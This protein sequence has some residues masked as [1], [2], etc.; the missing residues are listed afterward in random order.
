MTAVDDQRQVAAASLRRIAGL[1]FIRGIAIILVLCRHLHLAVP[2]IDSG[3][4]HHALYFLQRGGWC[5]VDLFFVLSGFLV[6]GILFR[7]H[8][9]DGRLHVGEFLI[10][11]GFKI[12]PAF[13]IMLEATVIYNL[14]AGG[15]IP[16]RSLC[17][18]LLFIQNYFK[19]IYGHTWSL[20]V[21]EHCYLGIVL[22]LLACL[23]FAPRADNPFRLLPLLTGAG[24]I[25]A[26]WLRQRL[27]PGLEQYGPSSI[28]FPTQLRFD[29]FLS[30]A[31]LAY[32]SCY[33]R[34]I[35]D[36]LCNFGRRLWIIFGVVLLLPV[37]LF[38][39]RHDP[40][41]IRWCLTINIGVVIC[42]ILAAHTRS[43]RMGKPA[44]NFGGIPNFGRTLARGIEFVGENSYSIYLWHELLE[45]VVV[46]PMF[47]QR[48][49]F[50]VEHVGL[51][52]P[53]YLAVT[54][55]GGIFLA[56]LIEHPTLVWRDRWFP[57]SD[58]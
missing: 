5:G 52:A 54:I 10:R 9:R 30:G 48:I 31:A 56:Y 29:G 4:L 3:W 41:V 37:F 44:A 15:T 23:R 51:W 11:R 53:V 32:L 43:T 6:S 49:T 22:L 46:R 47:R 34:P 7:H 42:W 14:L 50:P 36:R 20:A 21:E 57:R 13:W 25:T 58:D 19:G 55:A 38:D 26:W 40:F 24:L 45:H 16:V 28:L 12:Y 33:R 35:F 2:D 39:V 27:L 18:E 8:Q 17:I 1:D